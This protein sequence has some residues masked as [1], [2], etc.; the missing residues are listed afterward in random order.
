MATITKTIKS[1]S[2]DYTSRS[3]WEAGR[4]GDLVAAGNIELGEVYAFE[5]TAPV[6]I[7]GSV[8][9]DTCYMIISSAASDRHAGE[10][11]ATKARLVLANTTA[12]V[13]DD[14][15][16]HLEGEQ[17]SV[18]STS[19]WSTI[20]AISSSGQDGGGLV[21]DRTIFKGSATGDAFLYFAYLYSL[22]NPS[23][24]Y[25]IKFQNCAFIGAGA[26]YY[27]IAFYVSDSNAYSAY[28]SIYNCTMKTLDFALYHSGTID[29][30]YMKN[31]GM[32]D[33]DTDINGACT[34]ATNS[35]TTPTFAAGKDI[36]LDST[37]VTWTGQ[38]TDLSADAG[39]IN[40][41]D[42]EGDIRAVPWSIGA[43]QY[44]A[45]TTGAIEGTAALSFTPTGEIMG[46]GELEGNTT[47][48]FTPIG[49]MTGNGK[50]EGSSAL[51][52]TPDGEL[53]ATGKLEGTAE[54]IFTPIGELEGTG[55]LEGDT[56]LTFANSGELKG[57]GKLDGDSTL[58]FTCIGELN[59]VGK[60][61]GNTT[62]SFALD[63]EIKG[64]GK[65]EGD[66][67]LS[68]TNDGELAGTGKIEGDTTLT[69][70]P[71]GELIGDGKIEGTTSLNFI[72]D[73]EI[74]GAGK[75]E[76]T[77]S[78]DF[79]NSGELT[80]AGKLE[81]GTTLIFSCDGDMS[82]GAMEGSAPLSFSA[83][84]ELIGAGRLEGFALL[85]FGA[86]GDLHG[87]GALEGNTLLQ[88]MLFGELINT[89]VGLIERAFLYSKITK[90]V[91]LI[92]SVTISVSLDSEITRE[93]LLVSKIST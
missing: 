54:L 88:F 47:V 35:T 23:A 33:V 1:S 84:G 34:V 21:V 39:G 71:V 44:V 89:N 48:S 76:G 3:L 51:S 14:L 59:G 82:P 22:N 10:W 30:C 58:S 87:I 56:S 37:D 66:A 13:I 43:D 9:S 50:L 36:H 16:F 55:K 63:G 62:L 12:Y 93:I 60:I 52:F 68:F 61:E 42:I 25:R 46:A 45:V 79:I 20:S 67:L 90:S 7:S 57:S 27:K 5:D 70:T 69:F 28:I 18:T 72:S 41:L 86:Y 78:L 73:G 32:V 24:N 6:L 19:D 15:N 49:E 91:S 11:D 81:G 31:C 65:L 80:G 38:G 92:S 74:A 17:I 53:K 85:S 83:S 75:L 8:T 40:S 26:G 29:T 64:Y 2:G 77:A 4:Q